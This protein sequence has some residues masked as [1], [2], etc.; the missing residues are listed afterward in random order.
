MKI[1]IE[2]ESPEF[3]GQILLA[4]AHELLQDSPQTLR[5][6]N[7][8][9]GFTFQVEHGSTSSA[10]VQPQNYPAPSTNQTAPAQQAQ[11]APAAT[12]TRKRRTKE[13]I[14]AD[15]AAEAAAKA[16]GVPALQPVPDVAP[17]VQQ[18][19]QQVPNYGQQPAPPQFDPAQAA[20]YSGQAQQMYYQPQ[21][22]PAPVQN[23]PPPVT[24]APVQG[25][26]LFSQ[27]TAVF[28]TKWQEGKSQGAIGV[29]N[30]FRGPDG[31]P[32]QRISEANQA[33]LT[34]ILYNLN[35]L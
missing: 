13:Q 10:P 6:D 31:G 26:D 20:I 32:L 19:P 1:S 9:P 23:T 28:Q 30:M 21:Q 14:A 22:Y 8:A 17:P 5:S 25:N 7:Q 16:A 15:E 24:A 18:Q 12:G 35:Q 4:V 2:H 29:L 11:P 34:A 3:V 27:C 33:D